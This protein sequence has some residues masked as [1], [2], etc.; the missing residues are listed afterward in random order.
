MG[1]NDHSPYFEMIES[2][3]DQLMQDAWDEG[4]N[5]SYENA[6]VQAVEDV[7]E[8]IKTRFSI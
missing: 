6:Y 2:R 1:W 7:M 8:E 4:E 3:I 5:L